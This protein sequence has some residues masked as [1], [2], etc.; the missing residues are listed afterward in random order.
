MVLGVGSAASSSSCRCRH[1]LLLT[2]SHPSSPC[3]PG[4]ETVA[5][6]S[7]VPSSVEQKYYIIIQSKANTAQEEDWE[8]DGEEET[9]RVTD[10]RFGV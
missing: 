6:S 10:W 8:E 3:G 4:R 5:Y 9:E 2:G 7:G 1:F